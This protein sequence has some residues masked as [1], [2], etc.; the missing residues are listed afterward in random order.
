MKADTLKLGIH[1]ETGW[2]VSVV[3][4]TAE[5][6]GAPPKPEEAYDPSSREHL[7]AG[8]YPTVEDM[9]TELAGYEAV[10]KKHGVEVF[11]PRVIANC[12]QI[13]ARDIAFVVDHT[14]FR[15]NILPVREDEIRALDYLTDALTAEQV[16][17][18]PEE[19]HVEGGDVMPWKDYLFIGV[20]SGSDYPDY[21]TARTN[22]AA[23]EYFKQKC[24][25]RKV[26]GIELIKSNTDPEQNALHLDCCFQP[27]GKDRAIMCPQG[28]RDP[29]QYRWLRSQ[30]PEDGVF[31]VSPSEM[32]R[33]YCNIFSI[34]PDVVV[35]E[36][37]FV[38]L[39]DWLEKQGFKVEA[40]PFSEIAKQG[41]LLRC[42]TLPLRR[43]D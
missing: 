10:L 17:D 26:V 21:I 20:Y 32:A 22:Q 29:E 23:V 1:N 36:I 9:Q 30:F 16:C 4:G 43:E 24:P 41:G 42:T 8:T 33:M 11:R 27:V 40:I 28:F 25:H 37:T 6:T 35:S 2:L 18:L 3:L 34:S 19:V 38:R 7:I 31:E 15:S 12:N 5:A 13:F 39:N 14:L